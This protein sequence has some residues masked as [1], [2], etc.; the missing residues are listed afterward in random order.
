MNSEVME[1]MGMGGLDPFVF[2]VLF[3]VISVILIV[4]FIVQIN[5]Y[6]RLN[7]KF[8]AFM[9]GSDGAS[10]EEKMM[11]L[12]S[13]VRRLKEHDLRHR[14]DIQE[15]IENVNICY[16]KIGIV[17]YDAFREMG[18]QLSFSI[19]MLDKKDNGYIIN[20]VHSAN[21]CYVYT[22]EIENG[23]CILDLGDEEAEALKK[24]INSASSVT[25]TRSEKE[26]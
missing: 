7:K 8:Q 11:A 10:L 3:F 6:N 18:G 2:I 14:N 26:D 25:V 24:A 22:K 20:S 12:F 15:I 4:L 13:D 17:K 19:A 1:E 23:R 16:Q 9:L 5:K 21:G